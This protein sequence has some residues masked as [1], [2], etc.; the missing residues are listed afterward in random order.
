MHVF[1]IS[2]II[3]WD[4]QQNST[5]TCSNIC[6]LTFLHLTLQYDYEW[7]ILFPQSCKKVESKMADHLIPG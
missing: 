5:I 4:I 1:H 3:E 6:S 7:I 2:I